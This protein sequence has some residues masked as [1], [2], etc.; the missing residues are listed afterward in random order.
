[1]PG[2]KRTRD[3]VKIIDWYIKEHYPEK[4][5]DWIA[6]TLG[7]TRAYIMTRAHYLKVRQEKKPKGSGKSKKPTMA[8][9]KKR[10]KELEERNKALRLELIRKTDQ[11]RAGA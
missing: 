1:M 3:R 4:G 2:E 9:L 10:V 6:E 5:P 11:L 8:A 7:E